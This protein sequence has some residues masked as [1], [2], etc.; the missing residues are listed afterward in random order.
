[1]SHKSRLT[2]SLTFDCLRKNSVGFLT[3][4]GP[5]GPPST[6]HAVRKLQGDSSTNIIAPIMYQG[7]TCFM[8]KPLN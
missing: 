1:M 5:S 4:S 6:L 8:A 7:L 2:T 3:T